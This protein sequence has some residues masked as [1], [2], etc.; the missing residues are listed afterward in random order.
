MY[1]GE[2]ILRN[3]PLGL[4]P[5]CAEKQPLFSPFLLLFA[6]VCQK[7]KQFSLSLSLSSLSLFSLVMTPFRARKKERNLLLFSQGDANSITFKL[8]NIEKYRR[9][10][11]VTSLSS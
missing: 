9:Y 4:Q 1:R 5:S 7:A 8:Y 6:V 11:A 10:A 3:I 2:N